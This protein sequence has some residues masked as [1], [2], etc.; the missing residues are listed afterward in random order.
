[1]TIIGWGVDVGDGDACGV[2]HWVAFKVFKAPHKLASS[3]LAFLR[4]SSHSSAVIL[5]SSGM[6][7]AKLVIHG[8]GSVFRSRW[9]C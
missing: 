1:M 8:W 7:P 3:R 4:K 5:A 6:R 9:N 2:G